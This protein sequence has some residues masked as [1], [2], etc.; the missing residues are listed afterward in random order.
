VLGRIEHRPQAD[1]RGE[2][3]V[4]LGSVAPLDQRGPVHHLEID[5]EAHILELL[6]RDQGAGGSPSMPTRTTPPFFGD[7]ANPAVARTTMTPMS[8]AIIRMQTLQRMWH[9]LG[10]LATRKDR[11]PVHC[12]GKGRKPSHA[13][14]PATSVTIRDLAKGTSAERRD[15]PSIIAASSEAP[16]GAG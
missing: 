10:L 9:L 2:G 6:L 16:E 1:P 12:P 15:A 5:G 14:R 13:A 11:S 3:I 7:W 8:V 4:L